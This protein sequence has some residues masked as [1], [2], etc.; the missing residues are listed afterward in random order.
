MS[1]K[2][3]YVIPIHGL[4]EGKHEYVFEANAQFFE[5]FENPDITG[6]DIRIS[7]VIDKKVQ[8][9]QLLFHIRGTLRTTCDRCLEEFDFP[10][11]I[12]EELFVRFGEEAGDISDEVIIIPREESRLDIGQYI[13]EF[14]ALALP[15]KKVHPVDDEGRSGCNREMIERINEHLSDRKPD[16]DPRWDALKNLMKPT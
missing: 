1:W 8:F 7:L 14:S 6:G 4:K 10:V 12:E 11:D 2:D 13:Y 16:N 3:D 15:V 9:M 5:Y